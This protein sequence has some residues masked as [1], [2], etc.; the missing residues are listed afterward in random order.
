MHLIAVFKQSNTANRI[1]VFIVGVLFKKKMPYFKAITA[2][3]AKKNVL[4]RR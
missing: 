2:M 3:S 4:N 1:E